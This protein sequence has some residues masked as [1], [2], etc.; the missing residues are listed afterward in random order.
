[1]AKGIDLTSVE[2]RIKEP[3]KYL[4]TF[5]R[6]ALRRLSAP[7]LAYDPAISSRRPSP[8]GVS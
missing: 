7:I 5:G 3:L 2:A 4:L 8:R 6:T 1:M